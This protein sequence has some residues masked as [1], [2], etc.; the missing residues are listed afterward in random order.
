MKSRFSKNKF[1]EDQIRKLSNKDNT[2]WHNISK[3]K[4]KT[5]RIEFIQTGD[6]KVSTEQGIAELFT[7]RNELESIVRSLKNTKAPGEDKIQGRI[8]EKSFRQPPSTEDPPATKS[9]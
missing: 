4:R 7:S 1:L 5:T 9:S 2:L 8:V 6:A 3:L